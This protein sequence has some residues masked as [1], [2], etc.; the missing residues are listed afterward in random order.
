MASVK[1]SVGAIHKDRRGFKWAVIREDKGYAYPFVAV[2]A[3]GLEQSF[4]DGGRW[5]NY[6]AFEY[7]L[8]E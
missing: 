1:L 6:C 2:N 5:S 7:D 8:V 3:K 4:T